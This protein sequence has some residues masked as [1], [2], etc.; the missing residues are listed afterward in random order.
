MRHKA[1]AFIQRDLHTQA[2]YRLNFFMRIG[3]ILISVATF[4]FI[5][6][7]V[8]TAVNQYL[9]SYQTDY[10]H[11][12]L[13]GIAF[14]P[15][16]SL[17]TDVMS[18]AIKEYQQNGTLEILFLSPTPFLSTLVM[19]TLWPYCWALA[20]A[21][22]YLLAGTF[23][24]KAQ[25]NWAS[26][27]TAALVILFTIFANAG[28]GLIN[29]GFIIITKRVSP[30]VRLLGL[31]TSLLA[32]TYYPIDVLP[33]WLQTLSQVL[34]A[35]YAFNALRRTML[36]GASLRVVSEDLLILGLFSILL[37]PIG[38]LAFH[39]AVYWAKVDGSLSQY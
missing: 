25:L 29:A 13:L 14:F 3:R 1:L 7:A 5:S 15:F 11:F 32:G 27:F 18:D 16:I 22:V 8:G 17:S 10:F 39:Y 6:Q 19:S 21:L 12:V 36:Q 31:I 34:P 30:L 28:L 26:I 37:L 2:S 33:K 9:Q 20:E 38:L 23:I 24:F 35:T 4:Y